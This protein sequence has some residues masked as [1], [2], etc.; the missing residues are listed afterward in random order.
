[1]PIC[2]ATIPPGGSLGTGSPPAEGRH[3]LIEWTYR[4]ARTVR[5]V[6]P[7]P[8]IPALFDGGPYQYDR[9]RSVPAPPPLTLDVPN[10]DGTSVRYFLRTVAPGARAE[11]FVAVY[12]CPR[13]DLVELEIPEG[14]QDIRPE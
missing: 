8:A 1:L 4:C 13:H 12:A 11:E 3:S 2:C 10:G 6:L 5:R 7:P 14:L 9:D